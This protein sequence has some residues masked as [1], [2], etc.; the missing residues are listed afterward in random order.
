M[1]YESIYFFIIVK[2]VL[3]YECHASVL[4]LQSDILEETNN[5]KGVKKGKTGLIYVWNRVNAKESAAVKWLWP[6]RQCTPR[7]R[8]EPAIGLS[9][10]QSTR[11]V[12]LTFAEAPLA[13]SSGRSVP[14][15]ERAPTVRDNCFRRLELCSSG[16]CY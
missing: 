3:K 13:F 7:P 4:Q 6:H 16:S 5:N 15:V 11:L 8:V 12:P 9:S 2:G 1:D 14:R 10:G